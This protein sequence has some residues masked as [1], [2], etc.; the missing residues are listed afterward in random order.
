M[1][2]IGLPELILI[3]IVA[4]LVVGPKKL[5]D[6]ARSIGKALHQVKSV[7]DDVKQTFEEDFAA[8]DARNPE[9]TEEAGTAE[10]AGNGGLDL[11]G[12]AGVGEP[13]LVESPIEETP[14]QDKAAEAS[15]ADD[16]LKDDPGDPSN[17]AQA[18][19]HG[20]LRG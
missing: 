18:G 14:D 16:G 2:G 15:G 1:F 19:G 3:M 13:E 11:I 8:D 5:P 12:S 9:D 17:A 10:A 7:T 4:L 20:K 6:L